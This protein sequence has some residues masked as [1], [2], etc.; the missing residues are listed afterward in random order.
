MK[1]KVSR[2][3]QAVQAKQNTAF[4]GKRSGRGVF[5]APRPKE[6]FFPG[7]TTPGETIQPKLT[8]G[9]PNDVYEKEADVMANKV[10]Q[11]KCEAEDIQMKCSHCE[12]KEKKIQRKPIFESEAVPKEQP[13]QR[14]PASSSD[15]SVSPSVE[16]GLRSSKGGGSPL[17][18]AT[19]HQMETGF[20]ADF[21]GVRIHNDSGARQMSNDLQAQAFTH[22]RDIY[23]NSG[24]YDPGSSGGQHLLAHELT[25]VVQQQK[26]IV[27]RSFDQYVHRKPTPTPSATPKKSSSQPLQQV[28]FARTGQLWT[29]IP[30]TPTSI[31]QLASFLF[32]AVGSDDDDSDMEVG[33]DTPGFQIIQGIRGMNGMIID[34]IYGLQHIL[35]GDLPTKYPLRAN[36]LEVLK[37]GPVFSPDVVDPEYELS[38]MGVDSIVN[39]IARKSVLD[40]VL[41]VDAIMVMGLIDGVRG[42]WYGNE[43]REEAVLRIMEKWIHEPLI[44]HPMTYPKGGEYF[45]HLLTALSSRV[46]TLHNVFSN[47]ST[48]YFDLMLNH[49]RYKT[50][51]IKAYISSYSYVFKGDKPIREMSLWDDFGKQALIRIPAAITEETACFIE[52]LPSDT[53]KAAAEKMKGISKDY[54]D[55]TLP[56]EGAANQQTLD[57]ACTAGGIVFDLAGALPKIA[58]LIETMQQ[59][60]ELYKTYQEISGVMADLPNL[61]SVFD[62]FDSFLDVLFALNDNA[63]L[64]HLENWVMS[65]QK[66]PAGQTDTE[67]PKKDANQTAPATGLEKFRRII[68]D[69][70][71]IVKTIL[72]AIFAIR[73]KFQ[74]FIASA[75][76]MLLDH[77]I[78]LK[79]LM[80]LKAGKKIAELASSDIQGQL[81]GAIGEL[82]ANVKEDAHQF[83]KGLG[84]NIIGAVNG[85]KDRLISAIT[86]FALTKIKGLGGTIKA[87][88]SIPAVNHRVNDLI[89]SKLV[90]PFLNK[91]VLDKVMG[92]LTA[93][94]DMLTTQ[95]FTAID[96]LIDGITEYIKTSFKDHHLQL[97]GK[98]GGAT[99]SDTAGPQIERGMAG[100]SGRP[101]P[102]STRSQMERGFGRDFG[103]VKVHDDLSARQASE[104]L[105]AEAFTRGNDIY[106]NKGNYNPNSKDGQRLLAHELTHV[107]QQN[108]GEAPDSL[109]RTPRKVPGLLFNK[110]LEGFRRKESTEAQKV[111]AVMKKPNYVPSAYIQNTKTKEMVKPFDEK[112]GDMVFEKRKKLVIGRKDSFNLNVAAARFIINEGQKNP[113]IKHVL[114]LNVPGST[115]S[116]ELI[117]AEAMK[118]IKRGN[119]VRVDQLLSER[120]PCKSLCEREMGDYSGKDEK[121][122]DSHPNI[123]GGVEI[124]YYIGYDDINDNYTRPRKVQLME[125]YGLTEEKVLALEQADAQTD[126]TP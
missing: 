94:I 123:F 11:R 126:K 54:L 111:A 122:L 76:M 88:L 20:G 51:D 87:A 15:A 119:T 49:F 84:A 45:D 24:K 42:N 17:P 121:K 12:E 41:Q 92:K 83:I 18:A 67:H 60:D 79:V 108:K 73:R 114:K 39:F 106:F 71:G 16:S 95:A 70:L 113:S 57:I 75:Q 74:E 30:K 102:D 64:N 91:I 61:L 107:A 85:I 7:K 90:G 63:G 100:S 13:I 43:D 9:Q 116:E 40:S 62:N 3:T 59:V 32:K 50:D 117:L 124:F 23:F 93:G 22:G 65:D 47:E 115:H 26:G 53:A 35:L 37:M 86:D 80:A 99:A 2:T 66:T 96:P 5:G 4:F 6:H 44:Q 56:E 28:Y 120:R 55:A 36:I 21:S 14:K 25:H 1:S 97:K 82:L 38:K 29:A 10:V 105:Q 68:A 46:I 118:E 125:K 52:S 112:M 48:S 110:I 72:R 89:S 31:K 8:V 81:I 109:Q 77:P 19:R 69:L 98:E 58:K 27:Q 78:L 34:S 101:L 33:P 104:G 103:R